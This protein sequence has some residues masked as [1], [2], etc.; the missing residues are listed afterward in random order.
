MTSSKQYNDGV[1][2]PDS[3]EDIFLQSKSEFTFLNF[4]HVKNS[5]YF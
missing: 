5:N 2:V 4:T 1:E 3:D